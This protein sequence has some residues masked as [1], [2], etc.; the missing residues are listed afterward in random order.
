MR[1]I[2]I[3]V[4]KKIDKKNFINYIKCLI[5]DVYIVLKNF[6]L[7]KKITKNTSGYVDAAIHSNSFVLELPYNYCIIF[8]K[9]LNLLFDAVFINWKFT[10]Y[11]SDKED[12]EKKLLKLSTKLK[13][14]KVI[15]DTTDKSINI[16]KDE[17]LNEFDNVI[18]REKSKQFSNT[19]YLTTMLPCR[20]IDYKVS[21]KNEKINWFEIGNSKP[22]KNP[23]Y[24]IFFSCKIT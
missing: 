4:T 23:K 10:N 20:I 1:I 19:K 2:Y 24:D 7:K 14:K 3:P 12:I 5:Y 6:S 18:K 13:I 22:N 9:I 21:R 11:R 17:I 15:V 8:S 16:I